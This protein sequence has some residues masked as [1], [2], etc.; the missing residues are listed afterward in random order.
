MADGL[1]VVNSEKAGLVSK[2]NGYGAPAIREVQARASVA[3]ERQSD[4]E[5]HSLR[6][7][8]QALSN[9][10]PL[11]DNVPRGFYINIEV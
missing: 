1:L 8:N 3:S 11:R 9:E 6:R 4:L 2:S 10:Q 5:R 7:L